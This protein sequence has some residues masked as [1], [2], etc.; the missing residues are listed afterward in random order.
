MKS[1]S[2]LL[3]GLL[4]V[5]LYLVLTRGVVPPAAEPANP[6]AN[7]NGGGTVSGPQDLFGQVLGLLKSGYDVVKTI[8]EPAPK[9]T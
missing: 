7:P 9:T 4:G 5:V 8:A 1:N 3:Y 6:A 2:L